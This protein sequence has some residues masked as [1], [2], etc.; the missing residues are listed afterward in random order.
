[1]SANDTLP[2]ALWH[3][4]ADMHRVSEQQ[5]LVITH[6]DGC[7]VDDDAGRRYLDVTA[8]LWYCNIGHGRAELAEAARAQML[9]LATFH[10]FDVFANEPALALARRLADLLPLDGDGAVFFTNGGS[11]AVD[12]AGKLVRR[13]W[14]LQGEP[15]RSII[16]ARSGAYHGMN[17]FGTSFS[18]IEANSAGWGQLVPD[19]LTVPYDDAAALAET[20]DAHR[21]RV[22][23]VIGEMVIGAGGVLPPPDGYWPA[24]RA[25]CDE[26]DVLLIADEVVTGFGRLG[27][28][29]ASERYE[30]DPDLILGAKGVTSGYAPL[31]FVAAGERVRSA[32][33]SETA[34]ATRH[35]YTYSGHPTTCAVALAN[36]DI[37]EAED[38]PGRVRAIEDEFAQALSSLAEHPLV[39]EVRTAGLLAGVELDDKARAA[40]PGLADAVSA[41]ARAERL[42]VRPLVGQTL[43]ISPPLTINSEEIE[44]LVNGLRTAL[45]STVVASAELSAT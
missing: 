37:M 35:G 20:L 24:V 38:L 2:S 25:L 13:Y 40:V 3:P 32:F 14:R 22:A 1:M 27:T 28:W 26:H 41:A 17:A 6:G 44:F 31:G 12:T 11:D 15:Q 19:V 10:T 33:W 9:K 23:A 16:I 4:F 42:L 30:S 34:G 18:G 39:S 7:W 5:E 36:L 29:F 45:D 43:Q 8:G 21:G